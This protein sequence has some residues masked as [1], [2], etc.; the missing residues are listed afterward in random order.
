[1]LGIH[2]IDGMAGIGK[3][4]LAVH[5]AHR[6]AESFPDGQFFLPCTP[7]PQGSG[8]STRPM[9]WPACC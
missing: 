8:R 9:R 6:L 2:A 3:T 7:T 4:T 1:M 5:A